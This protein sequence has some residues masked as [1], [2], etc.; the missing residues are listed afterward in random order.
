[1]ELSGVC[2]SVCLFVRPSV[3]PVIRPPHAAAAGLLLSAVPAGD[4][5]RQQGARQQRR[6]NS[7]RE[8]ICQ[9]HNID[10]TCQLLYW[11]AAS[12]CISQS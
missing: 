11:Q 6:H 9:V 3:R 5:D 12:G 7:E 10:N 2:P 4:I 1:M 8:F